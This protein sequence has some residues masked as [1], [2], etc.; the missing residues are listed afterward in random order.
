MYRARI[1]VVPCLAGAA[2]AVAGLVSAVPASAHSLG[3]RTLRQGANGSDVLKLQ[4]GL[5][6]AG[7][8]T[9]AS[10]KYSAQT[11]GDVKRFQRFY[12]LKATG[13]ADAHTIAVLRQ[14]DKLDADADDTQRSGG[15]G[16]ST[17]ARSRSRPVAATP[18]AASPTTRASSSRA[19][20]CSPRQAERR[21]GAPGQPRPASWH[22]RTRCPRPAGL[23]D[24]R[25]L[26][27][28]VDGDFG[29]A[30]KSNVVS[31]QCAN[32]VNANGVFTYADSRSCARRRQGRVQ[33]EGQAPQSRQTTPGADCDDRGQRRRARPGERAAGGQDD[34]RRGEPDRHQALH[35]R[36]RSRQLERPGLRLLGRDQVRPARRGLP[37]RAARPAPWRACG[38]RARATG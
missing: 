17:K 29:P 25:R 5:S 28:D 16:L 14:V 8:V 33:P 35:L 18:S 36:R 9:P 30:T 4:S 12:Q 20:R 34:D 32:N 13:V 38:R 24:D 10:G 37:E 19:T 2:V 11:T 23:P 22:A 27:D 31:W 26:P 7:F 6:Q 3:S 21:L 1:R 15:C